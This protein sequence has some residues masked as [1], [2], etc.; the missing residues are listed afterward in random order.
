MNE[1]IPLLNFFVGVL[2]LGV[3]FWY[4]WLTMKLKNAATEQVEAMAK[5]CLT[6][7][8]KLRSGDEAILNMHGAVGG[9]VVRADDGTFVAENI[10]TGVALNV[11]YRFNNL[12]APEKNR[13][14]EKGYLLNILPGQKVA[15][16]EPINASPYCGSCQLIF[17]FQS[18]GGRS[19]ES[20]VTMNNHVLT[21]FHLGK[22]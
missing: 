14:Q 6:I 4:A 5:P 17:S 2:T 10:G 22:A 12:D 21:A 15:M 9:M 16:P 13:P 11:T 18:I 8:A 1:Y 19:Y 3:L 7:W 20:T